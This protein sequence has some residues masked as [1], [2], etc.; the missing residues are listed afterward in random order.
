[1]VLL[2]DG[3]EVASWPFEVCEPIDIEV[4]DGLARVQLTAMQ[5]GCSIRLRDV[6]DEVAELLDLVGLLGVLTGGRLVVDVERQSEQL[7][8]PQIRGVGMAHEEV[9]LPD[10]PV[11]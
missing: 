3:R 8:E 4:I 7:E 5:L 6:P 10:D 11:A 9:V 1:V 2:R